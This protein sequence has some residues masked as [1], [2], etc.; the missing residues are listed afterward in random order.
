MRVL[1]VFVRILA[2]TPLVLLT[3][4][5]IWAQPRQPMQANQPRATLAAKMRFSSDPDGNT[6]G[7]CAGLSM[8]DVDG[9]AAQIG[10][11]SDW[12][13]FPSSG[14]PKVHSNMNYVS[15]DLGRG[16]GFKYEYGQFV[17]EQNKWYQ[18]ELQYFDDQQKAQLLVDGTPVYEAPSKLVGRIYFGVL[19]CGA[20]NGDVIKADFQNVTVGGFNPQGNGLSN[21][22]I[23]YSDW[24]TKD[25]NYWGLSIKQTNYDDVRHRIQGASFHA[26]GTMT[27]MPQGLDW[28]TVEGATGKGPQATALNAEYWFGK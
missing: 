10:V 27:G 9:N 6:R 2:A 28:D 22:V 12:N 11:Q 1:P 24:N 21:D 19:I 17:F 14:V 7:Y 13:D 20:D 8:H 25:Y 23:P 4:S 26:E 18:L 3:C 15:V 5:L 16:L